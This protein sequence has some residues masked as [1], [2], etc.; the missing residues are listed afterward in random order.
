[1]KGLVVGGGSIGV[2]H[3]KN[4]QALGVQEI[5]LVEPDDERRTALCAE[6]QVLGFGVLPE[7]LN[8]QPD[9]TIIAAPSHL[10]LEQALLVARHESHLFVEKP[11]SHSPEG[12]YEL[13]N[14]VRRRALISLVGCNMR[15]HPGPVA[16]K[17]LIDKGVLGRILFARI[18]TGSYLPGWRSWQDYRQSYSASRAM[19]GGCLLD[20]IH[21]IDLAFW[22]LG[23]VNDVF[24]IASHLSS[25]EIDTEDVAMLICAHKG[26]IISEIHLD[27]VQR[28]YERGCQIVGEGGSIFWDFQSG[29]VRW[30][31]AGQNGWE[32]FEQ[33]VGWQVNQMY[34]DEM[35]HFLSCIQDGRQTILPIS[36]AIHPLQ[37]V[38]GAVRS[39]QQGCRVPVIGV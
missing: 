25:L 36:E 26:G 24:C 2:R 28:T 29:L 8:W 3:L 39:N 21:E 34:L 7:S 35:A 38:F 32:S 1:L 4:L 27:Y 37:I 12:I 15:F 16:V 18:H 31:D 23:Q 17:R 30:Y 33:P 9:F 14:E 20:C 5:A 22:Y 19:G 13:A 11:L 6:L 10:H